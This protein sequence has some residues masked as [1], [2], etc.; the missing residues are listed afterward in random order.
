MKLHHHPPS[1]ISLCNRRN[2]ASRWTNSSQN[3]N[4]KESALKAKEIHKRL[5][6]DIFPNRKEEN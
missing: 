1:A 3:S 6:I 4:L 2:T 5:K